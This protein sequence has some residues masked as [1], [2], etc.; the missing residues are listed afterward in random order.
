MIYSKCKKKTYAASRCTTKRG[1]QNKAP[2]KPSQIFHKQTWIC[3]RKIAKSKVCTSRHRSPQPSPLTANMQNV[4]PQPS[5]TSKHSIDYATSALSALDILR[6]AL[7]APLGVVG[8]VACRPI[9]KHMSQTI[10]IVQRLATPKSI[11]QL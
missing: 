9:I 7:H 2:P 11:H 8:L 3:R 10:L 1:W 4:L 6:N 5:V